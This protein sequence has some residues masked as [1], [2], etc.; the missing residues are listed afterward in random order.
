MIIAPYGQIPNGGW[1]TEVGYSYGGDGTFLCPYDPGYNTRGEMQLYHDTRLGRAT[2]GALGAGKLSWWK[3]RKLKAAR[4]RSLSGIPTDGDLA[5]MFGWMPVMSGWVSTSNGPYY[6]HYRPP[7]GWNPA[8]AYGPQPGPLGPYGLGDV[9]ITPDNTVTNP[10]PVITPSTTSAT[11]D[12]VIV[13]LNDHNAKMFTLTV[14]STLAV[15]ISALLTALR[16]SK[17]L[18]ADERLIDRMDQR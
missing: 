8:G 3:R 15:T 9:V 1:P 6:D 5:Q 2:C 16:T 7:N 14:V 11:A 4:A 18:K 17:L 13:A 10:A 12:D